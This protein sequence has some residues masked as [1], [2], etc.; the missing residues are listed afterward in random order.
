[1]S[2]EAVDWLIIGILGVFVAV[3]F[4]LG[5]RPKLE[6]TNPDI[7]FRIGAFL[8]DA[9]FIFYGFTGLYRKRIRFGG[10]L[11]G[12]WKLKGFLAIIAAIIFIAIGCFGLFYHGTL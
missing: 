8:V 10:S 6:V 2:E 9:G 5:F 12:G 1:M 4:Y 11:N 7:K 3:G